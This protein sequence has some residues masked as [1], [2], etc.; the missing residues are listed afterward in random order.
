MRILISSEGRPPPLKTRFRNAIGW[1]AAAIW[2]K[3]QET[4]GGKETWRRP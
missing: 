2:L 1:S 4:I 3:H